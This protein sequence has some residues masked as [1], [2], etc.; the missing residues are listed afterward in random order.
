MSTLINAKA[1]AEKLGY[2]TTGA[3]YNAVKREAIPCVRVGEAL[4][5]DPE[6]LDRWIEMLKKRRNAR[7]RLAG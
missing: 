2:R 4:R 3:L 1:A 6:E 7:I 5:F